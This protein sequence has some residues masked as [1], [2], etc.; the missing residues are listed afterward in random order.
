MVREAGGEESREALEELCKGYWHPLYAFVRRSGYDPNDAQ[1]LTQGFFVSLLSRNSIRLADPRR[2]RFR[3]FLLGS[4]SNFL[5]DAYR[6]NNAKK[7]GGDVATLSFDFEDAERRYQ[8]E[9]VNQLT[10]ER[11]F[12]REWALTTL[13]HV[14]DQL[15]VEYESAGQTRLFQQLLPHLSRDTTRLPYAE[16]AQSLTMKEG[17]VKVAAHRLKKKYRERLQSEILRTLDRRELLDEEIALL[18]TYLQ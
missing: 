3:T 17:A 6:R 4:M 9:P 16:I 8:R 11:I 14:Q 13:G 10:P 7:R 12:E 5:V 18:F 15:A 2:G 1:D